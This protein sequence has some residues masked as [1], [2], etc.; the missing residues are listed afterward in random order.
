METNNSKPKLDIDTKFRLLIV[1]IN[2]EGK[3][4]LEQSIEKLTDRVLESLDD[5]QTIIKKYLIQ[6]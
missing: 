6:S 4:K 3:G 5:H 1:L 2:D